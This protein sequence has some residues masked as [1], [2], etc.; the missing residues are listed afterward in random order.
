[1]PA[2]R[3]RSDDLARIERKLD[4]LTRLVVA[5]LVLQPVLLLGALL[6]D[7]TAQPFLLA[8]LIV[9]AILAAFPNLERWLPRSA[10]RVGRAWGRVSRRVRFAAP[11]SRDPQEAAK[12]GSEAQAAP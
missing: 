12:H 3:S 1:M 7:A 5:L 9:L 2:R 6:P 8:L 11:Q 10:R 4:R